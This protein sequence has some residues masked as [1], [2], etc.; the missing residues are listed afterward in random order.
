MYLSIQR[1]AAKRIRFKLTLKKR[2]SRS[3]MNCFFGLLSRLSLVTL[4]NND[5]HVAHEVLLENAESFS[6]DPPEEYLQMKDYAAAYLSERG[7]RL[8]IPNS[9]VNLYVPEG[10]LPPGSRQFIEVKIQRKKGAP[11]LDGGETWL[12]PTV[13]CGPSGL[14]FQKDV[15]LTIP[16]CATDINQWDISPHRSKSQ[17]WKKLKEPHESL[18]IKKQESLVMM[19]DHFCGQ[20]ISGSP[21]KMQLEKSQRK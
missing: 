21:K 16:H 17:G 11:T 3:W 19:M 15:F 5:G 13:K 6:Q 4:T 10:A 9:E 20:K 8:R 12:T 18:V 7:G 14:Q 2:N 1:H